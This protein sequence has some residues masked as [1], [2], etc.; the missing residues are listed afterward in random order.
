MTTAAILRSVEFSVQK[1]RETKI[2][3][4]I[5]FY[6]FK[7]VLKRRKKQKK[8]ISQIL[9]ASHLN[10]SNQMKKGRGRDGRWPSAATTPPGTSQ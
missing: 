5:G 2:G 4:S 10:N 9:V 8:N 6:L 7:K 1:M 3:T